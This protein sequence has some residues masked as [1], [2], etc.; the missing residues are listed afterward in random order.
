MSSALKTTPPTQMVV[1]VR[2]A[3]KV[4]KTP[5]AAPV[6]RATPTRV[7]MAMVAPVQRVWQG[8]TTLTVAPVTPVRRTPPPTAAVALVRAVRWVNITMAQ[9]VEFVRTARRI[10]PPMAAVQVLRANASLAPPVMTTM[11]EVPAR[12]WLAP[13]RWCRTPT[14][15]LRKRQRGF[16]RS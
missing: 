1:R 11:M 4:A 2:P 9:T 15:R 16:G 10:T 8:S 12:P 6:M 14:G 13:I 3:R 5:M 7:L